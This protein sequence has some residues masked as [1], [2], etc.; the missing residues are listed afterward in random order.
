VS[1]QGSFPVLLQFITVI[2]ILE[3]RFGDFAVFACSGDIDGAFQPDDPVV[4][5]APVVTYKYSNILAMRFAV[6][7]N[8][9]T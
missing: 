6:E 7:M 1:S 9:S 4:P 2:T 3:D 8:A 5:Y